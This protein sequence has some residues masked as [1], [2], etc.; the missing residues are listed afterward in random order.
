M[1]EQHRM[2]W[3]RDFAESVNDDNW[4]VWTPTGITT[5]TCSC[6]FAR[7]VADSDV[8][9]TIQEHHAAAGADANA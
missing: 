4:A 8:Q 2:D 6:G 9:A 1:S 5:V 3:Q 7:D